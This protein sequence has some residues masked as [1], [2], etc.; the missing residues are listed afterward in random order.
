MTLN[1]MFGLYF[2]L[3]GRWKQNGGLMIGVI[4][5]AGLGITLQYRLGE[6][7]RMSDVLLTWA[8]LAG[9]LQSI[10]IM[11]LAPGAIRKAV[12]K[13][14]Q[15][16][17]IESHR[18]TPM[19]SFTIVL[20]YLFGPAINAIAIYLTGALISGVLVAAAAYDLGR[21]A[22]L[23]LWYLA[24]AG[25]PVTGYFY[26][27]FT[28]MSSLAAGGKGNVLGVM[29]LVGVFGMSVIRYVPGLLLLLGAYGGYSIVAQI[30]PRGAGGPPPPAH[31]AQLIVLGLGLQFLFGSLFVAA[32][33]RKIRGPDRP[34]FNVPLAALLLLL[35][36]A[37]LVIGVYS[38]PAR[39][40]LGPEPSESAAAVYISTGLFVVVSQILLLA[41]ASDS[42]EL[43][44]AAA[45]RDI[46]ESRAKSRLAFY[47]L[48]PWLVGGLAV[49]IFALLARALD[50]SRADEAILVALQTPAKLGGII[51]TLMLSSFM[52]FQLFRAIAAMRAKPLVSFLIVFVATKLGP[53][54]IETSLVALP[55]MQTPFGGLNV[56]G[57]SPF[58]MIAT[59]VRGVGQPLIGL[60]VQLVLAVGFFAFAAR[61]TTSARRTAR[62][63]VDLP[64]AR[65][66]R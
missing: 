17:M 66:V 23:N 5:V 21:P 44:R 2:N 11:I 46:P 63:H 55:D 31:A 33:S 62:G 13:D 14:F 42:F 56:A 27:T 4:A 24:Q 47:A 7:R 26:A 35:S 19:G 39:D 37:A 15:N 48:T 32:A 8:L 18:L 60:G 22:Y 43:H 61:A 49:G 41:A 52:D 36:G 40:P 65:P 57:V 34:L 51:A 64:E 38:M 10:A 58:G 59:I 53:L 3:S 20:G 30:L 16:V 25:L 50:E 28:L 1:P 6:F 45:Y 29:F 54:L 9:V 12:A